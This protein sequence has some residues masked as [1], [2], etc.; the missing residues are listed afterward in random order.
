MR[1]SPRSEPLY[2]L[3]D[4]AGAGTEVSAEARPRLSGELC[5]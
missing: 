5:L 1:G 2:P 4:P 3:A